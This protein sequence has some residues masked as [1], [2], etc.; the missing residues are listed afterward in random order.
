MHSPIH[1][2]H[3]RQ[4]C[5][6]IICFIVLKVLPLVELTGS[7]AAEILLLTIGIRHSET[8]LRKLQH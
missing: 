6:M 2:L 1:Q 5:S 7:E 4:E 8:L 3:L